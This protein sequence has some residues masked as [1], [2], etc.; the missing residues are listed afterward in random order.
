[1][2]EQRRTEKILLGQERT[3]FG[4]AFGD[5]LIFFCRHEV[6]A[7][8]TCARFPRTYTGCALWLAFSSFA[9]RM[10]RSGRR[11]STP[12]TKLEVSPAIL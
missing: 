8:E 4:H 12:Y 11:G 5:T 2:A 9:G 3:G 6:Q 1:M 7:A 10:I